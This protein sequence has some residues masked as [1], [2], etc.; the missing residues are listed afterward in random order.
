MGRVWVK[1]EVRV[2]VQV[3]VLVRVRCGCGFRRRY[4]LLAGSGFN[5]VVELRW[6]MFEPK[7]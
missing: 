5:A 2:M 7:P 3:W 6:T 1:V 4:K